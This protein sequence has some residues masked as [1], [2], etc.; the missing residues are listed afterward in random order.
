MTCCACT[1]VFLHDIL[2]AASRLSPAVLDNVHP[3]QCCSLI[4]KKALFGPVYTISLNVRQ[5]GGTSTRSVSTLVTLR[6][7]TRNIANSTKCNFAF[8]PHA[9]IM[10]KITYARTVRVR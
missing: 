9:Y 3:L 5:E 8:L 2:S 1:A 7:R 10:G 6:L 4:E